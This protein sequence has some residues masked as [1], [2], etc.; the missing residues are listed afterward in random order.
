ML[1]FVPLLLLS[2]CIIKYSPKPSD[3]NFDS[4]KRDW[5]KVYE[6]EIRIAIENDDREGWY[7]FWQEYLLEKAR[8]QENN[9]TIIVK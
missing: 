8:V 2:G 9:E 3:T 6:Q 7:F 4:D 1:R 5:V